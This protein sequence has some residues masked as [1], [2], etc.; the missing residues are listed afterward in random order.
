MNDGADE[1][2][3]FDAQWGVATRQEQDFTS[4]SSGARYFISSPAAKCIAEGQLS[5][6]LQARELNKDFIN[7]SV[8]HAGLELLHQFVVDILGRTTPAAKIFHEKFCEEFE[9]SRAVTATQKYLAIITLLCMNLFFVYFLILKGYQKGRAWQVQFFLS[10]LA[11]MAVEL[12]VFETTECI[13]LNYS[14]PAYVHREVKNAT[15]KLRQL[16]EQVAGGEQVQAD[17]SS[18]VLLDAP[19]Q[20]FTSMKLAA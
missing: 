17:N 1:T 14:V 5:S 19:S 7:F 11:Q 10:C 9:D 16:V 15:T 3:L 4:S 20:L 18:M 2:Q 8:Q 13:W 12:F 6:D